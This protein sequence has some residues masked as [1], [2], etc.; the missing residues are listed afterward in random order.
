MK[1]NILFRF[2]ERNLDMKKTSQDIAKKYR[3]VREMLDLICKESASKPAFYVKQ[4]VKFRPVKYSRMRS[5]VRSLGASLMHRGLLG[6]KIMLLGDNCYPWAI[7]YL[8]ALCGL[9]I[10]I[11]INKEAPA[12]DVCEIAKASGAAAIIYSPSYEK[13]TE[14]LPKKLQKITFDELS[15][16]CEQG[17]SYSDA[18]LR[19]FDLL[20]IDC[21]AA[22]SIIF[23][24]DSNG[25]AKGVMLSQR[26][27]CAA[28]DG[29]SLSLPAE[30]EG[31]SLALLPLHYA[32]QS[33]AGLLFPLSQGNAVAFAESVRTTMQN[34]K[35]VC[36]TSIVCSASVLERAYKK[37]W[38]NIR[39]REIEEKVSSL[40]KATNMIKAPSLRAKAKKK[41][42]KE[43][44]EAFGGKLEFI[45]VGSSVADSEAIA[46]MRA[47]GFN[48]IQ[49]YG[50]TEAASLAAITPLN[51]K[52]QAAV[53]KALPSGELKIAEADGNG[54][55]EICYRGDNVMLGYY[56]QEELTKDAKQNGWIR[57]GD[58][59]SLDAD[60]YLT[61][62]GRKKTAI[63][64]SQGRYVFPNELETLISRNP[65]VKECAVIGIKNKERCVKDVV[66][67]I[68]PD[69]SYA[70]EILGVYSSRP[71]IKEKLGAVIADINSKLPQYK[72]I[73]YFVMLDDEIPKN[74]YKKV[75]RSTLPEYIKR[76][77]LAFED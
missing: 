72:R 8:T 44:H 26:N 16:L 63:P 5:D 9:S 61:V 29:L 75:D 33:I 28:L 64:A 62:F 42:F 36:P 4:G 77:Y 68:C 24:K 70:K 32:Y 76:E 52:N 6:K 66:A 51:A 22:A 45:M 15:V 19:E 2:A 46:G 25:A 65:Y 57:T 48:V 39:K 47:L 41:V 18:E 7:A 67:V 40:I 60:G 1:K 21:D 53:G 23:T 3:N 27:L 11:P 10:I 17:M 49:S 30:K 14:A 59:G 20:S 74:A 71:M 37:I 58:V 34:A 69:F 12:E 38:S 43:I 56:K 55:G 54:V 35:E 13:K 31:I 50:I 73:A